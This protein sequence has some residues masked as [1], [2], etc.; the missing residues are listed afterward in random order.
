M[1]PRRGYVTRA[2]YDAA[3]A[4]NRAIHEELTRTR[5]ELAL[6]A[7]ALEQNVGT[8]AAAKRLRVI[9]GLENPEKEEAANRARIV[10][11]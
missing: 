1:R 7:E 3:L 4:K 6:F 10:G 9:V 5:E 8:K 11:G 2:N